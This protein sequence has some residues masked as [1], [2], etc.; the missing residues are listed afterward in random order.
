VPLDVPVGR[1]AAGEK[2]KLELLKQLYLG[3]RFLILDEPTSVL[4]PSEADELLGMVRG[5]TTSNQLTCL[6]I[7]HKFREVTAFADE[8]SVLRRGEYAGGGKVSELSTADMAAMMI[9]EKEL[10]RPAARVSIDGAPVLTVKGAKAPDRS[11]LKMIDI[12]D[13]KVKSGEIVGMACPATG[14]WN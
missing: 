2:Q 11:G 7:S 12:A 10:V 5:L 13:L 1:L 8:V 3:R 14:R 9:G 6:M 4:T